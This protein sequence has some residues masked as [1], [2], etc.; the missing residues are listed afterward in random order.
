MKRINPVSRNRFASLVGITM[1]ELSKWEAEGFPTRR[2]ETMPTSPAEIYMSD[3]MDWWAKRVL[4][5]AGVSEDEIEEKN[6]VLDFD[7]ERA[8]QVKEA[9]DKLAL[10]NALTKGIVVY[11]KEIKKELE[12]TFSTLRDRVMAIASYAPM[13]ADAALTGGVA[14]LKPLLRSQLVQALEVLSQKND[15][16]GIDK[17]A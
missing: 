10:E 17:A 8:R 7:K 3:A 13:F 5:D 12:Y 16:G 4:K 14:K 15:G 9:A 6:K 11:K 2:N 1:Y